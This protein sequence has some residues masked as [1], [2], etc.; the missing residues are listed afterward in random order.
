[1]P[2][3]TLHLCGAKGASTSFRLFDL[4]SDG[5]CFA[6][7]GELLDDHV[8]CDHVEAWS[9]ERAVLARHRFQPILRPIAA[10][11]SPP[12]VPAT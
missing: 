2:T 11:A 9:G 10:A 3:Y 8:N 4:A 12:A 5:A 7:A 6:A 1:M